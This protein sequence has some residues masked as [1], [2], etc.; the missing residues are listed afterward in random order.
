MQISTLL[1]VTIGLAFT[2]ILLSLLCSGIN[3]WIA[4]LTGRR[5]RFLREGLINLLGSRWV[6]LRLVNHPLIAAYRRDSHGKA[7]NAPYL[8]STEVTSAL[9]AVLVMKANQLD[10]K[11]R[12]ENLKPLEFSQIRAAAVTCHNNGIQVG[13]AILPLLDQANNDLAV[14]SKGVA[15]WY[16]SSMERVTGWYTQSTRKVLFFIGVVMAV[17]LNIDSIELTRAMMSSDTLRDS[18]VQEAL[19]VST[20]GKIGEIKVTNEGFT[21]SPSTEEMESLIALGK[22]LEAKGLPIGFSCLAGAFETVKSSKSNNTETA[23]STP[24]ATVAELR[25]SCSVA[26][27]KM[28]GGQWLFKIIGWFITAMALTLGAP[29]WFD[30]LKRLVDL[31]GTGGKPPTVQGSANSPPVTPPPTTS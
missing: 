2:Y 14:A 28:S 29:F 18:I 13:S 31:R 7:Q 27:E 5:G 15:A 6:Y 26:R 4:H 3:E 8:P 17:V 11:P 1:E 30:L 24:L 21:I 9:F 22:G 12:E 19:K 25:K 23:G 10:K 16:D 20:T